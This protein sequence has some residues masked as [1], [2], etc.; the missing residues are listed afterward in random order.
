MNAVMRCKNVDIR[1][2]EYI[3]STRRCKWGANEE[4]EVT[5]SRDVK[6]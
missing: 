6:I 2:G 5:R 3:Q 1:I 4:N